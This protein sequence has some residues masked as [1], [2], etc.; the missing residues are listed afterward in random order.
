MKKVV[1]NS[2]CL[3]LCA[4][5]LSISSIA[6]DLNQI[7]EN[8]IGNVSVDELVIGQS[9]DILGDIE[10]SNTT[11]ISSQAKGVVER[12]V[13]Y[14]NSA[15]KQV[16]NTMIKIFVVLIIS[17]VACGFTSAND[18][19]SINNYINMATVLSISAIIL[20][21]VRSVL[22]L[23]SSAINEIDVL[24]KGLMPSMVAAISATG[25]PTTAAISYAATMFTF[26]LIVTFIN[27]VLFPF[28][29]IYIAIITVNSAIGDNILIKIADF[30]KWISMGSLKIILIVF[31]TYLSISGVVSGTADI[32]AVKTTK[33]VVSSAIPVVGSIISDATETILIGANIIKNSVGIF[34][35]FAVISIC[36]VPAI[37]ILL[38][39]LM[40]RVTSVMVSPISN[41][42]ITGL[43]D[44]IAQSFN[45]ALSMI[46][47]CASILFIMFTLA[48]IM[49][50]I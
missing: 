9:R 8:I 37:H 13:S 2:F 45:M 42:Q 22:A 15:F 25:A 38:N 47:S 10:I 30:I 29:Y 33:F 12:A 17:S 43:L 5:L 26:D 14:G 11:D 48:I 7:S 20:F 28:T 24:S 46:C 6:V 16:L 40:F 41:K 27:R 44:G 4:I 19:S 31:V 34:G 49:V 21:D 32:F 50:K 36:L 39:N 35:I 23:C 18:I 1:K 3:V